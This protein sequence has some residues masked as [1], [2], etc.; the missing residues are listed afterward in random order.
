M[1]VPSYTED[2]TDITLAEAT[3][4]FSA[5]GGGASGLG[6]GAD[7]AMQGNLCVDKQITS[8]DKGMYF[9]NGS[10]ISLPAGAH[11][12]VWLFN[13]TPGLADSIQN[14]GASIL[15]GTAGTAYCQYHVEGN[16]TYGAA[17][18]VAK[19]YPVN[20]SVRTANGSPPYR[21]VTGSPGAN[22]A[23]FGGGLVTTASVKGANLGIDAMRYGKG[24][25]ITAGDSGTPATFA[26][27]QAQNDAIAN[28]WGILTRVGGSFEL[29]GTF[30]IGQNNAGTATL[31]YF[32]DSDVALAIVDTIHS[33]TDFTK[34]IIDHASTEVYW[35][36]ISFTALGTNNAGQVIVNNAATVVQITG[37]T[38]TGIGI[39]TLRA[40][41][42]IDG[43]TW[44][45]SGQVTANGASISNALFDRSSASTA[46]SIADLDLLDSCTFISDGTGYAIDL[47][48]IAATT[49]MGWNCTDTGYAAQGG[50]A[51]NRTIL[52][53]V[54]SGQT[55]TIN[56]AAG[57]TTPTYNNTG[58]G[59]V[60]VVSGQ[61]TT[62]ITV[63]DIDTGAA[64]ENANV[65]VVAAAGGPLTAG[66]VIIGTS[67]LTDVSGQVSDTR[68]LGGNQPI[69]G[70]VRR[71][72]A[73]FG[74]L[75][76]TSSI[77]GTINAASGLDLTIQMIKDE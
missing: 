64:I 56:V 58:P 60:S 34:I 57:A 66:D 20:Y 55:L 8:A 46:L 24:A 53:N 22:P 19:C 25:F 36:N 61:V 18:R 54:A 23:V 62:T 31:A 71:A 75:Y 59:T 14:K 69:I 49:T 74:T 5:Y 48:T 7:L 77:V 3:T 32:A 41:C 47:G 27:F 44:R 63:V 17:G 26:G 39:T 30:A 68:S 51:T 1:A 65:Y 40:G 29:Q 35:T 70:R 9:N 43:L 52:V 28:R 21:S 38:W 73:G 16:D 45:T 12:W 76:K 6:T 15:V 67:T 2:L 50:T 11:V 72:T 42:V 13:A 37:G 10:G 33:A 4:G